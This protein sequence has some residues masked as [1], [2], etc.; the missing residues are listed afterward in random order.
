MASIRKSLSIH[1]LSNTGSIAIQFLVS[2][3]LARL[4]TPSEIGIF[5]ITVVFVNIAH[6]FREFG[7]S[8]Y[9]Q[10]EPEL[11]PEK[12]QAAT[13]V[14]LCSSWTIALM[15][16][17]CSSVIGNWFKEPQITNVLKILAAGFVFIPFGSVTEALLTRELAADKQAIVNAVGIFAFSSSALIFASIGF[18]A[19]SLAWANFLNILATGLAYAPFRPKRFP[20]S[21]KLRFDRSVLRFGAGSLIYHC[22]CSVNDALSD[23]MLGRLANS[24]DVGLMSRANSTVSIFSYVAGSTA[25]YG[26]LS[27]LSQANHRGESIIP[28]LRKA[29]AMLTGLGWPALAV[30]AI[31]G[32]DL[33]NTLYGTSWLSCIPAITPLSIAAAI[34]MVFHY[35]SIGITAVGHPYLQVL[36]ITALV[37]LRIAFGYW[38]FDQ[39]LGSFAWSICYATI[40]SLPLFFLLQR[41]VLHYRFRDLYLSSYKSFVVAGPCLAITYSLDQIIPESVPSL[42]RLTIV[43]PTVTVIWC[44]SVFLIKHP[45]AVEIQNAIRRINAFKLQS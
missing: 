33:V 19:E 11:S 45:L 21:I 8:T 26:A 4:L 14:V 22:V 6:I 38:L 17:L 40:F 41:R 16:Y 27:Y 7:V 20:V 36:P 43:I 25:N 42:A 30:T 12:V 29:T 34:S 5:S 44:I 31:F 35:S 37:I 24:T 39:T 28:V 9:L 2:L 32:K 1:L 3:L 23:L 15:L 13:T 18:G 10:R